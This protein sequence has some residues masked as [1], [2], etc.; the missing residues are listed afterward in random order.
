RHDIYRTSIVWEGLREPVQVVWRRAE[1][2]VTEVALDPQSSDPVADL[3]A[4]GMSMD[5]RRA[6]LIDLHVTAVA[7]GRWL[8]LVRAHHMVQDH[9][10]LEVLL[11]EVRAFLAGQGDALA[12]PLPFRDFVAQAR[13]GAEQA[14]HERYFAELLGDL[15]EPTTPFG[16]VDVHSDGAT[17]VRARVPVEP[18]LH[19][20][21]REVSRRL[22]TSAATVMHVAWARVLAAVSGR[23]DVVFGTVLFGRMNA[24]AGSTRV[25]GPFINTLPV[26]ARTDEPGV[27]AAVTAM[28]T[29]LARLLEHE[30][31]PLSVAQQASAMAGD[32][33]LFTC[34]L[35]YRH[36]SAPNDE[37]DDL[38]N[39]LHGI[40]LVFSRERTNYPLMVSVDDNGDSLS[41]AVDAVAP[42]D[43][44]AVG[45]LVRTAVENLVAALE[46]AL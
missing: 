37:G 5:L 32:T 42:V 13:G 24:G 22:G 15:D 7:E 21:L 6:P 10:A 14:E 4:V 43:P 16:L 25:P 3:L 40:R 26:R 8:G 44:Q 18:E 41:L 19:G 9:T 12:E 17:A 2:P 36:N 39:A 11:A 46:T 45:V 28:R 31:A 1:L 29:Q 38:D 23:D 35:N 27:L 33:P 20:R 30:H 34:F